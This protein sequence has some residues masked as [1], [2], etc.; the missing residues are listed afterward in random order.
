M[1]NG[2]LGQAEGL[3]EENVYLYRRIALGGDV[4]IYLPTL[5]AGEYPQV[6]LCVFPNSA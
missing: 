2:V 3:S 6:P 5:H 1:E 4:I